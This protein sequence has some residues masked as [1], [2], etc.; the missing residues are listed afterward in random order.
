MVA[1]FFFKE[2]NFLNSLNVAGLELVNGILLSLFLF[3]ELF[4]SI[5]LSNCLLLIISSVFLLKLTVGFFLILFLFW[6]LVLFVL[7]EGYWVI[8]FFI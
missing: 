1:P 7:L 8:K 5:F 6:S 3:F 2:D 4:L